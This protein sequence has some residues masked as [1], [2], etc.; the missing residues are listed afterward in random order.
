MKKLKEF[1][2]TTDKPVKDFPKE[3]QYSLTKQKFCT[4][5]SEVSNF[6]F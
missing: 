6:S 3:K 4:F 1:T 2:N 5:S